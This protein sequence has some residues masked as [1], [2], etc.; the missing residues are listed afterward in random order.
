MDN[1]KELE[2]RFESAAENSY[3][4]IS[5]QPSSSLTISDAIPVDQ[6]VTHVLDEYRGLIRRRFAP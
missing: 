6:S 4:L 1:V 3:E 2:T 5:L